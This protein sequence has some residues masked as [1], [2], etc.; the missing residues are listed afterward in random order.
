MMNQ[1]YTKILLDNDIYVIRKKTNGHF[2]TLCQKR[3]LSERLEK[4]G[5]DL[6]KY[7]RYS[8]S[9]EEKIYRFSIDDAEE[10]ICEQ[11]KI[12]RTTFISIAKG[13]HRFCS[14]RCASKNKVEIGISIASKSGWKHSDKTRKKMSEN[15]ADFSGDKNPFAKKYNND[16]DFR[17]QFSAVHRD[18]W[19][20]YD[21]KRMREIRE[22]FSL[23]SAKSENKNA[24]A[25]KKH[26]SGNY[27]SSKMNKEMFYRSS[28]ELEVCEYLND[29]RHIK[30][31]DIEPYCVEY[32]LNEQETRYTRLDFH[33]KTECGKE[34]IAEVKPEG[35][36]HHGNNPQKI[37][38][39]KLY[40]KENGYEFLLIT[41]Q[42]LDKL[43]EYI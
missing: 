41:K 24:N 31:F 42:I 26:K 2:Y 8:S 1:Q 30:W 14:N 19:A 33:I 22:T 28:W 37:E 25:H 23:A 27:Y 43:E 15:H 32:Q 36:I 10:K 35:L 5:I 39:L 12:N 17:N 29:A 21:D 20:S 3:V 16:P 18:R 9:I 4:S 38:G 40:A 34:I 13:W 7:E 11:C 6:S